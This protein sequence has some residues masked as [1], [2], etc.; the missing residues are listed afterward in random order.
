MADKMMMVPVRAA[1]PLSSP[2]KFLVRLARG[3]LI[4]GAAIA[5]GLGIG[6]W[7]YHA[8][9]GLPWLDATLN[10]AMLLGGEGPLAS[11]RTAEGKLFATIYALFSGVLFITATSVMLSPVAH[12]FLHRFHIELVDE[13]TEE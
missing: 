1:R 5:F 6:A 8:L 4:A 10:A 12:R 13:D 9:E 11:P 3:A 2:R 7:G